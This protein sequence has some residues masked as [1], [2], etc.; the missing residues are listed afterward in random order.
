MYADTQ[1]ILWTVYGTLPPDESVDRTDIPDKI[2]TRYFD[3]VVYGSVHRCLDHLPTVLGCYPPG[4]IVFLD[5]EDDHQI[6]PMYR[7]GHYFKREIPNDRHDLYPIEFSI[8]KEK[9]LT[10][11]PP[12]TRLLA[13]LIPGEPSTY[14]YYAKD[15]TPEESRR[16]ESAYYQQYAESYFG[17]TRRK[18]G[19][20]CCRHYE[21]MLSGCLPHFAELENC[22]TRTMAWLPK[23]DL[24]L[25]RSLCMNWGDGTGGKIDRWH[26]IY[27][28]VYAA[29]CRDLTTEAMAKHVLEVVA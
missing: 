29:L 12:K 19:W 4:K 21:I 14:I 26:E 13:P 7:S 5:G 24:L 22:P 9:I 1:P 16:A 28:R 6:S 2:R 27:M 10:S 15:A 11:F 20:D 25:A 8:P 3:A 18:G 23:E 17:Y